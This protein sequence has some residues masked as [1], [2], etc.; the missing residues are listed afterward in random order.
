MPFAHFRPQLSFD[1]PLRFVVLTIAPAYLDTCIN[2]CI[3][4]DVF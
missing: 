1:V 2:L 3:Y 4:I